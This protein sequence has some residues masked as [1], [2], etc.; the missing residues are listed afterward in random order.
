MWVVR[1]T[2]KQLEVLRALLRSEQHLGPALQGAL[3]GLDLARWDELP[4]AELPWDEVAEVA[5][6]QGI[7]EADV[8][9]VH[10]GQTVYFTILGDPDKRYYG[11][12]RNV[13]PAPEQTAATAQSSA[14][15]SLGGGTNAAIYYNALFDVPNTDGRLK[16]AM[17]AQVSVVLAEKKG[18]LT[19]PAQ[20]LGAKDK[21]GAYLVKVLGADGKAVDR[22]VAPGL[23]NNVKVE[24]VSGL[25]A[26]DQVVVGDSL[27]KKAAPLKSRLAALPTEDP[28]SPARVNSEYA[29]RLVEWL[30][31]T[32]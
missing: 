25:K 20:A 23:N 2:D 26:G 30:Q 18:V 3:E 15:G 5:R 6:R 24:I 4:E 10:P 22:K 32:L 11:K 12:I 21:G 16:A 17:T 1:L 9:N 14:S 29:S 7:S 19:I 27:G 8:I 28:K 13:E 31:K